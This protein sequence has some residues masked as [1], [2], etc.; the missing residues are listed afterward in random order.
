MR[1]ED[2]F[3]TRKTDIEKD[4]QISTLARITAD[5]YVVFTLLLPYNISVFSNW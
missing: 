5:Q 2:T 1:E 4:I 3:N